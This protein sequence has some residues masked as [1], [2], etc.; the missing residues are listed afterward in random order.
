MK[1]NKKLIKK[2][3]LY[4]G[5]FL[6]LLYPFNCTIVPAIYA[7]NWVCIFSIFFGMLAIF[8]SREKLKINKKSIPLLIVAGI[9]FLIYITRNYYLKTGFELK[10]VLY[11]MYLFLPFLIV[12][13]K[14]TQKVFFRVIKIFLIEHIIATYIGVFFEGFYRKTI[15]ALV[16]EVNPNALA[17]GNYYNGFVPGVTGHFST[18]AIYLSIATIFY[19]AELMSNKKKSNVI[20]LIL[21]IIALFTVGKRAHLIFSLFCCIIM[22]FFAESKVTTKEKLK[23]IAIIS[24]IGIVI[25]LIASIF[26]EEISNIFVRFKSLI[27][28]GNILNGRDELYDLALSLWRSHPFL[29][30]GWGSFSY[31]Y[32]ESVF[33]K[34]EVSY[35]DAH[36]VYLQLLAEVGIIG[37]LFIVSIMIITFIKNIKLLK[38]K[39]NKHEKIKKLILYFSL[40]YQLFFLLYG[41]TGNPLYDP[42]CYVVYFIVLSFIYTLHLEEKISI[43]EE[44]IMR[45]IGI[46][47]FHN[48]YNYGAFLQ[49]YALEKALEEKLKGD[50]EISIIEYT[51]KKER[52]HYR[53]IKFNNL[54][55]FI[56]SIAFL[57]QNYRRVVKFKKCIQNNFR[58]TGLDDNYDVTIAGSD[59]IWN[60]ELT[61]GYD[62]VYSLEY[63][64][65]AK[66]ISYASSVGD[67][68]LIKKNEE[69]YK[70]ILNNIDKISV[71]EESAQSELAKLTSKKID[72]NLDP[73]LLLTDKEWSKYLIPNMKEENTKYIFSYFVGVTQENYDVLNAISKKLNLPVLSYSENPKEEN[74]LRKC[75]TDNPFEFITRIKNAELIFTSSFHA[76]IFS[77]IFNKKFY[78][79]PPK[80][81]GNRILNLLCKLG[82]D[83]SRIINSIS[84]I[85]KV[86]INAEIK[87][88]EVNEKL[89]ALRNDSVQWL[90]NNLE[91]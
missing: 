60:I 33:T 9:I 35:L 79:M 84:D 57:P 18:N 32:Q 55:K 51:C 20:L 40:G 83:S 26:I 12:E 67:E 7:N 48:A 63:F 47:T 31:Y 42:Q 22:Y 90:K 70:K 89:D 61:G 81:K 11:C 82:I 53:L 6:V 49:C 62:K 68:S 19:M 38:Q 44:K 88:N 54:K 86:D 23:K 41:L 24:L 21:S 28:S 2:I 73:T 37:F 80:K 17:K 72:V 5:M 50:T 30:N 27:I 1:I 46:T 78:C 74:I 16:M 76:T 29:G 34:G 45:K 56:R 71:R 52:A 10:V 77:I 69:I 3:M 75:Y 59:Q 66:K 8:F 58:L 65:N 36:N 85:D 4:V 25:L 15:L 39:E 14:D 91:D 13:N 43:G 64:K 87:Y